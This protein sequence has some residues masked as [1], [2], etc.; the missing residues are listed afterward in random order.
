MQF[1]LDDFPL[2]I[3][4]RHEIGTP[5]KFGSSEN[6]SARLIKFLADKVA[7]LLRPPAAEGK[8]LAS[9]IGVEAIPEDGPSSMPLVELPSEAPNVASHTQRGSDVFNFV[10]LLKFHYFLLPL[11]QF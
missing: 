4:E 1:L 10:V 8:L 3:N 2:A 11:N 9:T 6:S 5:M 7:S